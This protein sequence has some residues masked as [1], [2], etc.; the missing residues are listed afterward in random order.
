MPT[1]KPILRISA[2]LVFAMTLSSC[3]LFSRVLNL[4]GGMAKAIT[5][6][7]T[8]AGTPENRRVK[9]PAAERGA[10]IAGRG[11]YLSPLP[12]IGERVHRA[13]RTASR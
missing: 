8:D 2:A 1:M 10:E 9:V 3:S 5:R 7:G 11:V 12:V 4:L 6:T 13:S